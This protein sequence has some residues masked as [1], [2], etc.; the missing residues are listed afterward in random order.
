VARRLGTLLVPMLLPRILK[1]AALRRFMFRTVSQIGIRYRSSA[2]SS[3]RAGQVHGGDRLPW[4]KMGN[5]QD[6]HAALVGLAWNVHIY[7]EVPQG[8]EEACKELNLPV[9]VFSW[10]HEMKAAGLAPGGLYLLR[11]DSYVAMAE[12]SCS[13]DRLRGYFKER[14]LNLHP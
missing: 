3:G 2:I 13:P 11:P 8:I 7:G 4:F 12:T 9:H 14:G 1:V 10:Q 5:G 6:N